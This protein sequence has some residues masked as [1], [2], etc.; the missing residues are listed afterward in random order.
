MRKLLLIVMAIM[1]L[2]S[3]DPAV[4]K[5][6]GEAADSSWYAQSLEDKEYTFTA[7][8]E[9]AGLPDLVNAGTTFTGWTLKLGADIDLSG[10]EWEPIGTGKRGD[11]DTVFRGTFDGDGHTISNFKITFDTDTCDDNQAI[12]FFGNVAGT[13]D[14]YATVKNVKFSNVTIETKSNT[15]GVAVGYAEYANIE[16]VAVTDSKVTAYQGAGAVIG[17]LY[18]GGTIS[19]CSNTDT[20]VATSSF[21]KEGWTNGSTNSYPFNAGGI[22]GAAQKPEGGAKIIVKNNTVTLSDETVKI[23]AE[24]EPV[25]GIV[26]TFNGEMNGNTVSVVSIDQI[27]AETAAGKEGTQRCW[28]AGG[29]ASGSP[30][31][32]KNTYT[33]NGSATT[34]ENTNPQIA[35]TESST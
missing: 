14:S 6:D 19:G 15:A 25:G 4:T 11:A 10:S 33:V 28:F 5:W 22:C 23:S 31:Y 13:A 17:R 16:N 7:A 24:Y 29:Q 12:G 1:L 35:E 9:L 30:T 3:C 2:V 20:A 18:K 21:E 27:T 32:S 34:V 26:G 8:A